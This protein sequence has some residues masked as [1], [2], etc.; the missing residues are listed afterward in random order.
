MSWIFGFHFKSITFHLKHI[1][2]IDLNGFH[3]YSL[4]FVIRYQVNIT[5]YVSREKKPTATERKIK[6]TEKKS[7]FSGCIQYLFDDVTLKL[8]NTWARLHSYSSILVGWYRV[9]SSS[10]VTVSGNT[11]THMHPLLSIRFDLN[12]LI[13]YFMLRWC[14]NNARVRTLIS[15]FLLKR[16]T[17]W[18]KTLG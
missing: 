13:E 3:V 1:G 9:Y 17:K 4:S 10:P 18:D 6:I 5:Q 11:H 7:P 16:R 14:V 12:N 8:M 15:R 2:L